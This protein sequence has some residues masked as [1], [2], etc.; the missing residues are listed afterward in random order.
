[1]TLVR[2]YVEDPGATT[3]TR[4]YVRLQALPAMQIQQVRFACQ[5]PF[6]SHTLGDTNVTRTDVDITRE[7]CLVV[8]ASA[9]ADP[10]LSLTGGT[11]HLLHA[12]DHATP[13]NFGGDGHKWYRCYYIVPTSSTVNMTGTTGALRLVDWFTAQD[14]LGTGGTYGDG[15]DVSPLQNEEYNQTFGDAVADNDV[16]QPTVWGDVAYLYTDI[17]VRTFDEIT[18]NY[19]FHHQDTTIYDHDADLTNATPPVLLYMLPDSKDDVATHQIT[20]TNRVEAVASATPGACRVYTTQ[21]SVVLHG[22]CA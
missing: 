7:R 6:L 21:I 12:W 20:M 3:Y 10:S 14:P 8:L 22:L 15:V 13:A 19:R 11:A 16:S 17:V 9:S 5:N 4:Q 2:Q 18:D 1:M